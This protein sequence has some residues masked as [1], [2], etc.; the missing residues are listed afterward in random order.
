VKKWI[1]GAVALILLVVLGFEVWSA[2]SRPYYLDQFHV[3]V[4]AVHPGTNGLVR[5]DVFLTNGTS[6]PLNVVDDST[7][8]PVF[9]VEPGPNG[10]PIVGPPRALS[11]VIAPG[12]SQTNSVVLTN[13]PARFR[14]AG[15]LRNPEAERKMERICRFLPKYFAIRYADS[16]RQDWDLPFQYSD[17]VDLP[18]ATNTVSTE[19]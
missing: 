7:G 3:L 16:R 12:G 10:L 15:T 17:W 14:L 4:L 5:L 6:V 18:T 8:N 11:K 1:T 2:R 19:R 9:M 13:P